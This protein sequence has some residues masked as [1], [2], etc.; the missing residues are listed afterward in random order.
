MLAAKY[1]APTG[2]RTIKVDGV[3]GEELIFKAQSDY[4]GQDLASFRAVH[5]CVSC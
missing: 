5:S 4:I 2:R 3:A 1:G